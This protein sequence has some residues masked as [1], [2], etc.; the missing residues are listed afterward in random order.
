[1]KKMKEEKVLASRMVS[2][3]GEITHEIYQGDKVKIM[4]K[5]ATDYL[6]STVEVGK[7]KGFVKMFNS[8]MLPL[9]NEKLTGNQFMLILIIN[10][11]IRYDSGIISFDNGVPIT[12][13]HLVE[14]SGMSRSSVYDNIDILV[15]KKILGKTK[16]GHEIKYFCNPYIFCKGKRVNKTLHEMFKNSKWYQL[17]EEEQ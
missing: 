2:N 17:N 4:R 1:M 10:R 16:V 5:E 11:Y 6:N 12:K 3:E 8:A 15:T 7:D 9:A 13:D 14:I